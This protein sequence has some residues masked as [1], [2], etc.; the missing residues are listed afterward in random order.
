[1][2]LNARWMRAS[3]D[4]ASFQ[5]C[6]SDGQASTGKSHVAYEACRSV[7]GVSQHFV[8]CACCCA[9]DRQCWTSTGERI[10]VTWIS[11]KTEGYV[12]GC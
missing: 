3:P 6:C 1:M 7:S 5:Y 9:S 8:C 12:N 11:C 10:L 2:V 4:N